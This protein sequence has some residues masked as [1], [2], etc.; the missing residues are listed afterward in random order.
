MA[1]SPFERGKIFLLLGSMATAYSAAKNL[2]QT[3]IL[4]LG[5]FELYSGS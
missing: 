5:N 1:K 4:G 2:E 3:P